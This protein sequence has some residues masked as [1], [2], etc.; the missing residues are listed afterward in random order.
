MESQRKK[1]L[2][3]SSYAPPSIGG[4][5]NLYNLLRDISPDDY[6]I[7][8]SFYNIDNFSA[9][10]G[11]WLKGEYIFYDN[12]GKSKKDLQFREETEEKGR[13]VITKLKHLMKRS[14]FFRNFFGIPVILSQIMMITKYGKKVAEGSDIRKVLSVSDY[15]PAMISSYFVCKKT[16]KPLILFLFD[17]YK[18]NFFPFPGNILAS[19]FEPKLFRL[20]EKI[21]VT[22]EGTKDFYIKI[23]GEKI[24]DKIYIIHNSVFPED[25]AQVQTP[26]NPKPPYKIVFTGRIYWPQIG[27]LKNLLKAVEEINDIDVSVDIYTTSPRDYLERIEIK[28]SEKIKI[29][30]ATPREMPDI[31]GNA[32]ILFLPLSWG[33]KSQAIIDTATPGKLTD[34]LIAGRPILIHAPSSSFLVKYAKENN[35]AY[36]ADI[37]DTDELK[38]RIAEIISDS[39]YSSDLIGNAREV[40]FKNH[41]VNK[42]KEKFEKLI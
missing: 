16:K 15:G 31:Q 41:D 33:T 32:D 9:K 7:L 39:K 11:S 34:Y 22:N 1:V 29:L 14:D 18:G 40:F 35:F 27:A 20:A 12:F 23:Y 42:N 2:I 10:K 25:Y 28:E 19:I 5:Q 36:V 4:P 6:S 21:I 38:R 26:Y 37:D 17:I 30:T 3:I 8:T 24:K 13:T